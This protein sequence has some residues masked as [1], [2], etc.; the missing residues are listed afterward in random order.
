[1]VSLTRCSGDSWTLWPGWGPGPICSSPSL[2]QNNPLP[3]ELQ[4][5]ALRLHSASLEPG[6]VFTSCHRLS[7]AKRTVPHP[8]AQLPPNHLGP[9]G[10]T[11]SDVASLEPHW[12]QLCCWPPG[13]GGARGSSFPGC[14]WVGVSAETPGRALSLPQECR[15]VQK[16]TSSTPFP[17][18]QAGRR[19]K[20]APSGQWAESSR[21]DKG[22]RLPVGKFTSKRST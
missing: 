3:A 14:F 19:R 15:R 6:L 5:Q 13:A 16:P 20:R 21:R 18:H 8:M 17:Q 1:M 12:L 7:V 10:G 4:G 2:E 11:R 9:E 22:P